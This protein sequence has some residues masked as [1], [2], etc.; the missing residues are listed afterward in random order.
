MHFRHLVCS[1]TCLF[2][3]F[4]RARA[5]T[6]YVFFFLAAPQKERERERKRRRKSRVRVLRDPKYKSRPT[7]LFRARE[8]ASRFCSTLDLDRSIRESRREVAPRRAP[9]LTSPCALRRY[10]WTLRRVVAGFPR[11]VSR[12][13]TISKGSPLLGT[14][15]F[16]NVYFTFRMEKRER[17]KKARLSA[18]ETTT[19]YLRGKSQ[20]YIMLAE[21]DVSALCIDVT[22]VKS[23]AGEPRKSVSDFC[24]RAAA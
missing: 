4:A 21:T 22:R 16:R 12:G 9:N 18:R 8:T 20:F 7:R 5:R 14:L 11:R 3:T 13:M 2:L 10:R 1:S 19:L 6:C 15:N 23:L 24:A 17:K